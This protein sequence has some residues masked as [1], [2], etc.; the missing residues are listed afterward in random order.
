MQA[1]IFDLQNF[2]FFNYTRSSF[3][4][5]TQK[6]ELSAALTSEDYKLL[7]VEAKKGK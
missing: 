1:S 2:I 7:K 3:N 6:L 4:T 5:Y